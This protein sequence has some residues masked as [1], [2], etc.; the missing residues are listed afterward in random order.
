MRPVV[1]DP[2]SRQDRVTQGRSDATAGC[3]EVWTKTVTE[4]GWRA[5]LAGKVHQVRIRVVQHSTVSAGSQP[6]TDGALHGLAGRRSEQ[7]SG[8]GSQ[9]GC[10]SPRCTDNVDDCC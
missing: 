4:A 3:C 9:R 5:Q 10:P 6:I 7:G 8:S 1:C 2:E